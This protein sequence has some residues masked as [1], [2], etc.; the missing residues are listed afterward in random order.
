MCVWGGRGWVGEGTPNGLSSRVPV[1]LIL[2]IKTSNLVFSF[3][4]SL[5]QKPNPVFQSGKKGS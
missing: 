2:W 3:E 1:R 4:E 5:M